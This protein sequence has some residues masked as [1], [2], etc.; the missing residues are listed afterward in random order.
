MARNLY[1]SEKVRSEMDLY[2]DL[3]IESL[4]IYGQD[5]YYLPRQ[6]MNHDDLLGDDVTSRFPTSHK[7]EMY[8]ENVE[9]F[10]G[11]GDLYTLSLIHI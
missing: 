11:E 6:L 9:G 8:I 2:A 3:V 1:F 7:I 10:D 4:K 5:V